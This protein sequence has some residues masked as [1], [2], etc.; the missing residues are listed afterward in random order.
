MWS[1]KPRPDLKLASAAATHASILFRSVAR[2]NEQTAKIEANR[3]NLLIAPI[4]AF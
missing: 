4:I 3:E 1:H 2:T